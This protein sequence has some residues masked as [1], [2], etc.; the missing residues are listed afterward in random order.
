MPV[1]L[2]IAVI[3]CFFPMV[4]LLLALGMF[5]W[6]MNPRYNYRTTDDRGSFGR[7]IRRKKF[8]ST[9][10]KVKAFKKVGLVFMHICVFAFIGLGVAGIFIS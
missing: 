4:G 8:V 1:F 2:F 6:W 9:A 7:R 3:F 5:M 10:K